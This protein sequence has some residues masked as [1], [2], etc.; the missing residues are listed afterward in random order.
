MKINRFYKLVLFV[1][2]SIMEER[3]KRNESGSAI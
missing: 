2:V 1:D 3:E